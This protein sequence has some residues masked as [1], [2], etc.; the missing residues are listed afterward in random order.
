MYNLIKE[1]RFFFIPFLV[2]LFK[3]II[4]LICFSKTE[5]HILSNKA[6]SGFFDM[7]FKQITVLGNGIFIAIVFI[8][9]PG[10]P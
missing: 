8:G 10:L 5:L 9:M 7:F 3:W 2:L 1:N 6:N 4:L